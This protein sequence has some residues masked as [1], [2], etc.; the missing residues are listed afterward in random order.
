MISTASVCHKRAQA[1][2]AAE[3][4]RVPPIMT[5]RDTLTD[6]QEK[7]LTIRNDNP[8]LTNQQI[9]DLAETSNSYVSEVLQRYGLNKE[10]VNDYNKNKVEI[11]QGITA[12][13][14]SKISDED[15]EK[16]SLQQKITAAGIAFDKTQV[17]T[18]GAREVTPMVIVNRISIDN[19]PV[20]NSDIIT[21]DNCE[22]L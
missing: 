9:A 6:K 5:I 20:D 11:W 22:S 7:I 4:M 1:M 15:I 12:R 19:K 18:G 2:L 8:D 10:A 3:I 17:L 21:V 16:G 14:L 13:I